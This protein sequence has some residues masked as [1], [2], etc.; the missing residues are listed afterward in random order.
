[1][2]DATDFHTQ[3]MYWLQWGSNLSEVL[4]RAR[5]GTLS[6]DWR[7]ALTEAVPLGPL[8]SRA[9]KDSSVTAVLE[10]VTGS[11]RA[12]EPGVPCR[13]WEDALEC[14]YYD[15]MCVANSVLE[16]SF[17]AALRAAESARQARERHYLIHIA[18]GVPAPRPRDFAETDHCDQLVGSAVYRWELLRRYQV[19]VATAEYRAGLVAGGVELPSDWL[20]WLHVELNNLPSMAA[21]EDGPDLDQVRATIEAAH[22]PGYRVQLEKLPDYW[23]GQGRADGDRA[24]LSA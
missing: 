6:P 15:S 10:I 22:Q 13:G 7:H 5:F 4:K 1:M 24:G 20:D 11:P 12:W 19:A 9:M 3:Q 21:L 8:A 16:H 18:G 14:W 23:L 2:A 17:S